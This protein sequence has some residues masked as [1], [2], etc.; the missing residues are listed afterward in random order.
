MPGSN[1]FDRAVSTPKTVLN[2][3]FD[4]EEVIYK[5]VQTIIEARD[6]VLSRYQEIF[7]AAS[8]DT[9]S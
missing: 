1:S 6:K 4:E 2:Y 3:S 8:L 7:S 9:L 5:D